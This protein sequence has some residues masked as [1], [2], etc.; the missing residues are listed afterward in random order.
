MRALVVDDDE[1]LGRVLVPAL[2]LGL[3][4]PASEISFASTPTSALA[5]LAQ[6][7]PQFVLSDFNLRAEMT[8]LE[9][10]GEVARMQPSVVRILMS[11]YSREEIGYRADQAAHAFIEKP[12]RARDMI[13]E[14]KAIL[15]RHAT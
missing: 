12:L 11:G 14:L 10:L 4:V 15:A 8:G 7:R 5:M 1:V 13:A 6:G 3:D 2:A 9:L